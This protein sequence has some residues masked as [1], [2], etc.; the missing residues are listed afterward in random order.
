MVINIALICFCT[1]NAFLQKTVI[2]VLGDMV[3]ESIDD[4][5]DTHFDYLFLLRFSMKLKNGHY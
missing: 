2:F 5:D 1:K 4:F 3:D